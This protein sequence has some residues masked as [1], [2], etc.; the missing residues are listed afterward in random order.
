ML[1]N[2]CHSENEKMLVRRLVAGDIAAFNEIYRFYFHPV[3]SNA[4]KITRDTA[5]AED[6]LQDVFITLWE[7]RDTIDP[8]RSLAGWLFVLCYNRS[9]NILKKRLRESLLYRQ[10]PP[11]AENSAEEEIKFGIQWNI[12]ENAMSNLSPQ[13]RRVFELCK[14]QGK[15]YEQAA[16]EL[17]ISKYTVKE[18]LSAALSSIKEYSRHHPE[19]SVLLLPLIFLV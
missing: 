17:H 8:E 6:I 4:V 15:S 13:R 14:L 11:S 3:Y 7:K 10:L 18:Y 2:D 19:T 5:V 12:L 1:S 9:I 16:A